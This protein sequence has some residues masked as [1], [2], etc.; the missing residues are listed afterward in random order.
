MNF[1]RRENV[2]KPGIDTEYYR[3][4]R[5]GPRVTLQT[6]EFIVSNV[7]K[8]WFFFTSLSKTGRVIT[9]TEM[10]LNPN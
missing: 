7:N 4:I 3:N 2:N 1:W 9:L 8:E 5:L 6:D 10:G